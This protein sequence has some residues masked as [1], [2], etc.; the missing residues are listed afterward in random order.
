MTNKELLKEIKQELE[1]W[2]G[3]RLYYVSRIGEPQIIDY[4]DGITFEYDE[5]ISKIE[6][7]LQE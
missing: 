5:L 4:E 2:N 1:A 6:K 3:E 7:E